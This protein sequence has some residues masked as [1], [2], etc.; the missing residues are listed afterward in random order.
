MVIDTFYFKYCVFGCVV[1]S[2]QYL[3][4][5]KLT[6]EAGTLLTSTIHFVLYISGIELFLVSTIT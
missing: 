6:Q 5:S 2:G 1:E 4:S 3:T